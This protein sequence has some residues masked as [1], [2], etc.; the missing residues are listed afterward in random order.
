MFRSPTEQMAVHALTDNYTQHNKSTG[1]KDVI[2]SRRICNQCETY[3]HTNTCLPLCR[4]RRLLDNSYGCWWVAVCREG[5]CSFVYAA[6]DNHLDWPELIAISLSLALSP[7]AL[8]Q[9]H[10]SPTHSPTASGLHLPRANRQNI[11][12]TTIAKGHIVRWFFRQIHTRIPYGNG[13]KRDLLRIHISHSSVTARNEKIPLCQV[14]MA[15]ARADATYA[16]MHYSHNQDN[17]CAIDG[18]PWICYANKWTQCQ[19]IARVKIR[20][21]RKF[22]QIHSRNGNLFRAAYILWSE[23]LRTIVVDGVCVCGMKRND[24]IQFRNRIKKC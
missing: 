6:V 10:A 20:A 17:R 22:F 8:W 12:K 15:N 23:M 4:L 18:M 19:S 5:E 16:N 1:G 11:M 7:V 3:I 2:S 9:S 21:I 14:P 24:F 13:F